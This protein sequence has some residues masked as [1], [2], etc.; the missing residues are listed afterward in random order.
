METILGVK[1]RNQMAAPSN[2]PSYTG[3]KDKYRAHFA[4]IPWCAAFLAD[5]T[6]RLK[7]MESRIPK[8]NTEDTLFG[9]T[10]NGAD[11]ISAV[12]VIYRLPPENPPK[13]IHEVRGFFTIGNGLNGNPNMLHGGIIA[14]LLDEILG[15]VIAA[16]KRLDPSR[17]PTGTVTAYLNTQYLKPLHTPA[18]VQVVGR[19]RSI[20]GRKWF[21]DGTIE[22]GE[23]TVFARA[24]SLFVQRRE[25]KEPSAKL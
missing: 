7:T 4:S 16:N 24:D 2:T 15:L 20:E 22:D 9:S 11:N 21:I 14:T 10:L 1:N 8:P 13:A 17:P 12:L 25:T 6:W 19:L 3:L 18:T 5:P 23:G